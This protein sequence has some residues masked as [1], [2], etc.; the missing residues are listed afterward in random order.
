MWHLAKIT[1]LDL[2]THFAPKWFEPFT[3][4]ILTPNKPHPCQREAKKKK[5]IKSRKSQNPHIWLMPFFQI[6][7]LDQFGLHH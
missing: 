3:Q 6:F 1:N 2:G 5:R 7:D 4:L